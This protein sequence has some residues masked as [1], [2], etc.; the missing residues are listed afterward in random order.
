[1]DNVMA[2]MRCRVLHVARDITLAFRQTKKSTAMGSSC[3]FGRRSMMTFHHSPIAFVPY[4]DI[5]C[6][7][8]VSTLAFGF[9]HV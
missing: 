6:A 1:M 5:G 7:L 9:P 4:L 8:T 2:L 3:L